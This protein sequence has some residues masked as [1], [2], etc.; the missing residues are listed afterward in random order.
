[1]IVKCEFK[2]KCMGTAWRAYKTCHFSFH[3]LRDSHLGPEWGPGICR[4]D[5]TLFPSSPR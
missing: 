4:F 1:M 2:Y 5:D 3:T